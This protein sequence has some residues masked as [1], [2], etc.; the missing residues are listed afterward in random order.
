MLTRLDDYLVHQTPETVDHVATSDRNFYDRYY[1]NAHTLDGRV[2]VVVAMGMYPNIGVIDAFV[3]CVIDGTTQYIVRASRVLGSERL[4]TSAGPIRVEVLEGLQRLRVVVEPNEHD[5]ALDMTF[6]GRTFPIHEPRVFRRSGNRVTMDSTRLTQTG[7]W[8]GS[9]TVAGRTYDVEPETWWGARDHSWGIR[10]VGGAEP[11]S[12]PV[13][14]TAPPGVLWM[15]APAQFDRL[16]LLYNAFEDSTGDR[17]YEGAS[18]SIHG[19]EGEAETLR[20]LSHDIKLVPGTRTFERGSFVLG[21]VNGTQLTITAAPKS[22]IYMAGAG[23]VYGADLWRHGQY[24]APL[25]VEGETWDLGDAALRQRVAGQT[26]T[27][28][29]FTIAEMPEAGTGHGVF[30]FLLIGAY[31]P[32]GFSK[33]S[34]VAPG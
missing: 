22:T 3:T 17:W 26:Q 1:F 19:A 16:S 27:I 30:E 23:Y 5:I 9:L 20:T 7:R 33:W 8:S 4:D 12:A 6:E 14:A 11:P 24:H 10:G 15:W 29:D 34:D 18:L 2:F 25:A 21:R 31:Q 13:P 32:Y 28:C